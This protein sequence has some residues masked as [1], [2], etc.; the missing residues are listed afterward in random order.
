M[1]RIET[2]DR[3]I[4][5]DIEGKIHRGE[6]LPGHRL[7]T[8]HE[9]QVHYKCAR[10]TVGKALSALVSAGLIE[11]RKKAGTTVAYP[12]V[13]AAVLTI[14][15]IAEVIRAR[16]ESYRFALSSRT[17]RLAE[18]ADDDEAVLTISGKLLAVA[19]LHLSDGEPFAVERR[20]IN[21]ALV[22]KA[23]QA[24]FTSE[25]P[26][27]WLLHHIPWTRARHRIAAVGCDDQD[28]E[29]LGLSTGSPCLQLDRW[30]WREEDGVTF[31]RQIFPGSRYDLV[32]E[33]TPQSG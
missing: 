13:H 27:S 12:R 22:P 19:G 7:P 21:L 14:P 1:A 10:A 26:G 6:W 30:T 17:V 15:D 20:V 18:P 24:D 4:R 11:R 2:L 5:S 33:F 29:M 23:E 32:A 28:A 31:V 9:L 8:E 3:R 25:A 16:G